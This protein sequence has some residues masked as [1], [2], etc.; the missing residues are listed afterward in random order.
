M[1]V[2]WVD[3]NA[4]NRTG[5]YPLREEVPSFDC[6][7]LSRWEDLI[8]DSSQLKIYFH[9]FPEELDNE[10]QSSASPRSYTMLN[11]ITDSEPERI[12]PAP[13]NYEE[14]LMP[15]VGAS[16]L[17]AGFPK[18]FFIID[19]QTL[20]LETEER[21]D[22]ADVIEDSSRVAEIERAYDEL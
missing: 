3:T 8:K 12:R 15:I 1:V 14:T 11:R 18:Q 6:P 21:A 2:E 20:L 9:A 19:G 16:S 5:S 7:Q 13:N 17:N 10:V 22:R 4:Q